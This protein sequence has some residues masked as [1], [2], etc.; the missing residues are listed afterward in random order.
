VLQ[1]RALRRAA[2][3]E[4]QERQTHSMQNSEQNSDFDTVVQLLSSE[5]RKA[6]DLALVEAT[7]LNHN[8]IGTEHLL[9]GLVSEGSLAGFLTPFNVT[10]EKI[11]AGLIFIYDRMPHA[12]V[13][14]QAI[15]QET[16]PAGTP[17]DPLKMLTPRAKN[18]LVLAGAEMRNQGEKI[19]RPAHLLLGLL[20]VQDGI[21]ARL[22]GTLGVTLSQAQAVLAPPNSGQICSF[23]GRS[24]AQVKRLFQAEGSVAP[25]PMAI[26]CDQCVERFHTLLIGA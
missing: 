19:L 2:Q 16:P 15:S 6:I 13:A 18:A 11:H 4:Q 21:G 1:L 26:V 9:W 17:P 14:Q 10:P 22:L 7:T 25:Q 24:G 12:Q 8:F 5:S 3:L 20:S 23:C